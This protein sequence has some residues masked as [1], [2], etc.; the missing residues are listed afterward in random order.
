MTFMLH[1]KKNINQLPR[2]AFRGSAFSYFLDEITALHMFRLFPASPEPAPSEARHWSRCSSRQVNGTKLTIKRPP[3]PSCTNIYFSSAIGPFWRDHLDTPVSF[4]WQYF[5][6]LVLLFA[7]VDWSSRMCWLRNW[8]FRE[9]FFFLFGS[10]MT[11]E[12][13]GFM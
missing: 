7:N 11:L 1:S 13:I 6:S 9:R 12:L 5:C 4:G 3:S 8:L 10:S 2:L